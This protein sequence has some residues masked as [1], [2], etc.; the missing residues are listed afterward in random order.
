M[1]PIIVHC[2]EVEDNLEIVILK[3]IEV[4]L[5]SQTMCRTQIFKIKVHKNKIRIRLKSKY[6]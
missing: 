2:K 4:L 1:S 3:A 6:N 5:T